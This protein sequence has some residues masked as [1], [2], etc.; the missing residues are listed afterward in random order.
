[1][2]NKDFMDNPDDK[3]EFLKLVQE[4]PKELLEVIVQSYNSDE[5]EQGSDSTQNSPKNQNPASD[6]LLPSFPNHGK[7]EHSMLAQNIYKI[8]FDDGLAR[9][10]EEELLTILPEITPDVFFQIIYQSI[11]MYCEVKDQVISGSARVFPTRN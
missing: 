6:G 7:T 3:E 4:L 10:M 5:N 1:M 2:K 9:D 8:Y 11:L